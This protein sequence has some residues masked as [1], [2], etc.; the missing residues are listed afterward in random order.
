LLTDKTPVLE[1]LAVVDLMLLGVIN[2][3]IEVWNVEIWLEILP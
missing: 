2:P 3:A 1:L